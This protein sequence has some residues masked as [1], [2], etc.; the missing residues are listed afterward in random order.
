M[1]VYRSSSNNNTLYVTLSGPV[2]DAVSSSLSDC[3][4]EV[5]YSNKKFI[6]FD[7]HDVPFITS[8]YVGEFALLA[9]RLGKRK[10]EMVL[11]GV[12]NQLAILF[13][14]QNLDQLATMK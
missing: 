12:Q 9:R 6:E 10:R 8:K 5:L 13:Q 1:T 2:T 3:F 14:A 7:F 11:R 4:E